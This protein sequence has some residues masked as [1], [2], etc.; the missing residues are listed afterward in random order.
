[1]EKQPTVLFFCRIKDDV[2]LT[3]A[4]GSSCCTEAKSK[5]VVLQAENSL[6][7]TEIEKLEEKILNVSKK[8]FSFLDIKDNPSKVAH[9]TGPPNS[10]SFYLLKSMVEEGGELIYHKGWKVVNISHEDQLFILLM[11]LRRNLSFEDLGDRFKV[12]DTTISNVVLTWLHAV[13]AVLFEQLMSEM[14]SRQKNATS[15]PACFAKFPNCRVVLDCAEIYAAI[16]KLLSNH[17]KL[18]SSYKHRVTFKGLIGI[19]PNGTVTFASKLYPGSTSDKKIVDHCGILAQLKPGDMV[20]ADKGFL[21]ANDL[22][23]G[24]TLNIPPFSTNPQF[25]VDEV[26]LT[27]DI[28]RARIHVER[29]IERIK[30]FQILNLV[31]RHLFSY[32]TVIFQTCAALTNLMPPL[33]NEDFENNE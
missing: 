21:I 4:M 11:K 25:T 17:R 15:I 10:E 26:L 29:A 20:M 2:T 6:L 24:V 33:V 18:F 13:H 27:N 8:P 9:Y 7:K 19:A 30:R 1:M 16:P 31:D 22:P 28:A 12:S 32:S 3:A 23:P 14:P 5:V